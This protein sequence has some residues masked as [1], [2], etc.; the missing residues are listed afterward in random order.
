MPSARQTLDFSILCANKFLFLCKPV[1][2]EFLLFEKKKI[3]NN[4]GPFQQNKTWLHD[5]VVY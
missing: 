5:H 4:T 2:T 1:W 3:L